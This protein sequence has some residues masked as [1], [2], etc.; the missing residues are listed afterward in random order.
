MN[1]QY[2]IYGKLNQSEILKEYEGKETD[3]ATTVVDN[4]GDI[5][6]VDVKKVPHSLNIKDSQSALN[7]LYSGEKDVELDLSDY[8]HQNVL[9]DLKNAL[10]DND[11]E[12]VTFTSDS[13]EKNYLTFYRKNGE[14][15]GESVELSGFTQVQSNLAETNPSS[16]SYIQ[17]KS[18]Q[19]LSNDGPSPSDPSYDESVYSTVKKATSI[20]EEK[21]NAL[22]NKLT[23]YIDTSIKNEATTRKENDDDILKRIDKSYVYD[24]A[25][26]QQIEKNPNYV[27]ITQKF[28]NIKDDFEGYQTLQLKQASYSFGGIMS[29]E[30]YNQI[31]KNTSRIKALEG[32]TTRL[33]YIAKTDPTAEDINT[34]V[35]G[36]GYK[37]PF[38]G[39]AVVVDETYHIWHYYENSSSWKDDGVD[40]VNQFTNDI[41]GII[42]GSEEDGKVYAETD[43][44]G[45]VY[46]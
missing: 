22:D 24:I 41:A 29:K 45:S 3:T 8:V 13:H 46:G 39:I 14:V 42:K 10:L 21:V 44:T 25:L 40:T 6:S 19:Y 17:N 11:L 30:D 16:E 33:L 43:G 35:T 27:A 7:L 23:E 4:T 2:Y 26:S 28:K 36:L 32:K 34:F 12:R 1:E 15:I 20:T 5:I 18:T 37:A 9:E 38:E 31:Q